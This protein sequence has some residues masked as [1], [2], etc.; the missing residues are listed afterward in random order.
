MCE[1]EPKPTECD[2][3]EGDPLLIMVEVVMDFINA[4]DLGKLPPW[5]HLHTLVEHV[6]YWVVIL[7]RRQGAVT[8][9]DNAKIRISRGMMFDPMTIPP[10]PQANEHVI[11]DGEYCSRSEFVDAARA[12]SN[13]QLLAL[14]EQQAT[15]VAALVVVM[16]CHGIIATTDDAPVETYSKFDEPAS[17]R[18]ELAC[19]LGLWKPL[20]KREFGGPEVMT[21]AQGKRAKRAAGTKKK[22]FGDDARAQLATG[23]IRLLEA[24]FFRTY[25]WWR[26]F[27]VFS[28]SSERPLTLEHHKDKDSPMVKARETYAAETILINVTATETATETVRSRIQLRIAATT[29][30]GTKPSRL[31]RPTC[32]KPSRSQRGRLRR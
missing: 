30:D 24:H 22:L 15:I 6:A 21:T 9:A 13:A 1:R 23:S 29:A 20:R 10:R 4:M 17:I 12:T 31:P 28:L 19:E 5:C 25:T 27:M 2:P 14:V 11:R 26:T 8:T 16:Q 18:S 7:L 32:A 3:T